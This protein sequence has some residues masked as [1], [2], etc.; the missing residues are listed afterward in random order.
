[1]NGGG[2]RFGDRKASGLKPLP[3]KRMWRR[4]LLWKG[5]Q[6]RCF[7]LSRDELKPPASSV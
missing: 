2:F 1:M 5:L 6:P 4:N 7:S 3:Q